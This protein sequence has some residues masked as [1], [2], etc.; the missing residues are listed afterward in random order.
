VP[1]GGGGLATRPRAEFDEDT[2]VDL[3]EDLG[4]RVQQDH[5]VP[6]C[7][8]LVTG[9]VDAAGSAFVRRTARLC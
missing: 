2:L 1:A 9:S 4:K 5:G 7:D 3:F 8:H 6:G